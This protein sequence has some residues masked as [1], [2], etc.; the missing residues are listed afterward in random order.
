MNLDIF[1]DV[2]VRARSWPLRSALA[3]LRVGIL[4]QIGHH[5]L[6]IHVRIDNLLRFDQLRYV[7]PVVRQTHR[8]GRI[9]YGIFG[10]PVLHTKHTLKRSQQGRRT[11]LF[12]GQSGHRPGATASTKAPTAR[13]S[14]QSVVKLC[15]GKSGH[16]PWIQFMRRCLGVGSLPELFMS[17]SPSHIGSEIE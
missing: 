13:P 5:R 6:L 14:F 16:L 8:F 1:G 7:E 2:L 11:A 15:I 12:T 10:I 9:L 3:Q 4:R 17:S